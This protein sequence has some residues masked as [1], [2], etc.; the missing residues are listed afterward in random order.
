MKNNRNNN[1][2]LF[3]SIGELDVES[4]HGTHWVGDG[5]RSRVKKFK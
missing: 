5:R 2:N 1:T 3:F 4:I